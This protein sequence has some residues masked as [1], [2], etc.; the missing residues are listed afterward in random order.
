MFPDT[1]QRAVAAFIF[2]L[3]AISNPVTAQEINAPYSRRSSLQL[4]NSSIPVGGSL[5]YQS[6][7]KNGA[8]LESFTIPLM[9]PLEATIGNLYIGGGLEYNINK[10][11]SDTGNNTSTG[12]SYLQLHGKYQA[13]DNG[14]Y[15]IEFRETLNVPLKKGDMDTAASNMERNNMAGYRLESGVSLSYLTRKAWFEFGLGHKWIMGNEQYDPGDEISTAISIGYG[16][17]QGNDIV[18]KPINLIVGLASNY[19]MADTYQGENVSSTE[20]GTVFFTPG[21]Q[22]S[23]K[24]MI[25]QAMIEL[26]VYR[27]RLNHENESYKDSIRANI[28]MKYYL[29]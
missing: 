29:R 8:R 19:Y 21:L 26:P 27:I 18:D 15:R 7:T 25:F 3:A 23:G 9:L 17:G 24:S 22:L 11:Q 13:V 14:K 1:S 4:T 28:G 5:Q 20:Y 12:T 16:L 2:L 10:Y 6:Q